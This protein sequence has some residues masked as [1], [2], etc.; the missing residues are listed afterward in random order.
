[1]VDSILDSREITARRFRS[2]R[3]HRDDRQQAGQQHTGDPIETKRTPNVG[4]GRLGPAVSKPR[5]VDNDLAV[6]TWPEQGEVERASNG[7][8][9]PATIGRAVA[10]MVTPHDP[11]GHRGCSVGYERCS[12]DDQHAGNAGGDQ[13]DQ[14]VKTGRSPA[15]GAI[16][17]IAV[18]DHA[19]E[20]V[21]H[22]VGEQSRQSGGQIGKRRSDD[23]IAEVFGQRFYSGA[24]D[25]IFVET[26]RVAADDVSD[27]IASAGK[28]GRLKADCDPSD[29]VIEA[30]LGN[31]YRD[32]DAFQ[33]PAEAKAPEKHADRGTEGG[34]TRNQD[35][36][37]DD[38]PQLAIGVVAV[39][40][41]EPDIEEGYGSACEHDRMGHVREQP[42]HFT[43]DRI[44]DKGQDQDED[45][46]AKMGGH[47]Q[48]IGERCHRPEEWRSSPRLVNRFH[49]FNLLKPAA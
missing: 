34:S 15:E 36:E 21:D 43:Q 46:I 14:I 4:R 16:A 5:V 22:L 11:P 38:A 8:F 37:C 41:V 17:I 42:G 13:V 12:G 9:R 47:G 30:P 39:L 26:L 29:M 28:P 6:M 27:R 25:R 7:R 23:T 18:P 48:E 35:D 19:V 1:M 40:A 33:D 24:G 32:E 44:D 2:S 49:R 31:Q 10:G 3:D 20:G 45:A